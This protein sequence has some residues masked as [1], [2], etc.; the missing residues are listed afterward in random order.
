MLYFLHSSLVLFVIFSLSNFIKKK[1]KID[2]SAKYLY[3]VLILVLLTFTILKITYL[4]NWEFKLF[5]DYK[6]IVRIFFILVLIVSFLG[7]RKKNLNITVSDYYFFILYISICLF[8]YDRYFLDEDEFAFWG[9][10]IK[11]YYHI[12]EIIWLKY[13]YYH[14]PF[15]TSWQIFNAS[16]S[17]FSEN[18]FIFANNILLICGFFYL[19]GDIFSEKK[20]IQV[21]FVIYFFI[22]YLLLNNL[23]FGFVSIYADTVLAVFAACI[24]K[25]LFDNNLNKK[26]LILLLL[27]SLSIYFIHRIGVILLFIFTSYI[28]LN[29]YFTY[30][31]NKK[32]NYVSLFLLLIILALIFYSERFTVIFLFYS[33]LFLVLKNNF[34]KIDKTIL[35]A[36]F[37]LIICFL[38]YFFYNQ[39]EYSQTAF[40]LFNDIEFFFEIFKSYIFNL[41]KIL[42]VDIY[43]SSFGTSINKIIELLLNQKKLINTYQ[44]NIF[45]WFVIT[46]IF[47][48]LHKRKK[49]IIF[50][51]SYFLFYLLVV[52]IEKAFYQKLSFLV[53][54]RYVSIFLL[55]FLLFL[56][57]KK[58]NNYILI[59]LLIL[60]I[61]ITPLKSFGFFV[62]DNIYY[63]YNKNLKYFE[64]RKKIKQFL[65]NR[66]Y[67]NGKSIL[68]V[69]DKKEFPNYLSG[70]YSLI[71]HI[72]KFELFTSKLNFVDIDEI[73]LSKNFDYYNFY[74]CLIVL[75]IKINK[76]QKL[77]LHHKRLS[78]LSI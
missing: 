2:N 22:F 12:D 54:S 47:L 35:F 52:Y 78:F 29:F 65:Y 40:N 25:I 1:F 55:S 11:D 32:I 20:K 9:P 31:N 48:I 21:N 33:V 36:F 5:L 70:H 69:Y 50:F 51:V 7:I 14:Q 75:N 64:N 19:L 59:F 77:N 43:F 28:L 30:F 3:S 60:N 57:L 18:L 73:S 66:D 71:L 46:I 26:N 68:V 6:L 13:N 61:S 72:L 45:S 24:V 58:T 27:L 10:K 15:L 8:S 62:P 4:L 37:I 67:C 56:F 53:F 39:L 34:P 17:D 76:F 49:F 41:K 23:S 44:L 16:F 38:R 42:L 74:E 63:S